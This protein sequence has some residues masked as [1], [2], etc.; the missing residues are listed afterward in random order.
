MWPDRHL[1]F[2]SQRTPHTPG[3]VPGLQGL[4]TTSHGDVDQLL[5]ALVSAVKKGGLG[6]QA[7]PQSS[8]ALTSFIAGF[9]VAAFLVWLLKYRLNAATAA[10]QDRRRQKQAIETVAKMDPQDLKNSLGEIGMPAWAS[11][12]DFQRVQ[13]FNQVVV[14]IWP[15]F[16]RMVT[17]WANEN[18]TNLLEQSKPPWIRSVRM[19]RFSLGTTV[20]EITGVKVYRESRQDEVLLDLDFMWAGDQE[21]SFVVKPVPRTVPDVPLA[22][23]LMDLLSNAV[24][25]KAAVDHWVVNGRLR[26]RLGPLLDGPPI[27]GGMQISLTEIP[28]FSFDLTVYGGE[29]AVLPGLEPWL[30][31]LI[32]DCVLRPYVLPEKYD[33]PFTDAGQGGYER[34][35]GLLDVRVIEAAHV[36]R[37]DILTASDPFVKVSVR[38]KQQLQTQVKENTSKPHWDESFQLLVHYPDKQELTLVMYDHDTFDSHDEIGRVHIP[39]RDL[40]AGK[41]IDDWYEVLP[42]H[43]EKSDSEKYFKSGNPVSWVVGAGQKAMGI[44]IRPW[45]YKPFSL[46]KDEK[47]KAG[48]HL[49]LQLRFS[50]LSAED[51]DAAA[52]EQQGA[53][54]AGGQLS[55]LDP[56][57]RN[58][59]R[60]GVLYVRIHKVESLMGKAVFRGGWKQA[61][62]IKVRLGDIQKATA[63]AKGKKKNEA[64]MISQ[65]LEFIVGGEMAKSGHKLQFEVW[66]VHWRNELKGRLH[67]PFDDI[68]DH[69]MVRHTYDLEG[70]QRG[71]I[72]LEMQW[73]P[74]FAAA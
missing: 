56:H 40:P 66:D 32:E 18:I 21:M 45:D 8:S 24:V 68:K 58:I 6:P 55:H 67:I 11:L 16:D 17:Q 4:N 61:V 20:P 13:W 5:E 71:R 53:P 57:V 48:C 44:L 74:A 34:P 69:V 36:P 19:H 33:I 50:E 25:I 49:H 14:Q 29:L 27:L 54:G 42:A 26:V 70:T 72:T 9:L 3:G 52:K 62:K 73:M 47:R 51:V 15:Y 28:R 1:T 37:L 59:L 41:V 63:V 46:T 43:Q 35:R 2:V 65:E 38:A 10:S 39:V 31:A 23:Q 30:H 22:G 7:A 60:G 64:I 12:P